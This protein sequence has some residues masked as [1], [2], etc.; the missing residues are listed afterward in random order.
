V[1]TN[2]VRLLERLG[3]ACEVREYP[4][5]RDHLD[6]AAVARLLGLDPAQVFKTLVCRGDR[7]GP[8]FAVVPATATLDLRALARATGDRSVDTVPLAQVT[9][10]TGYQRGGVTVLAARRAF[11]AWIDDSADGLARIAVSAGVRGAQLLLAPGDYRRATG[12]RLAP[13]ALPPIP[14]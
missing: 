11:P 12:A 5:G 1:K 8:C 7:H 2:A 13:I 4:V 3:I 10:L 9:P 14:A 6:A